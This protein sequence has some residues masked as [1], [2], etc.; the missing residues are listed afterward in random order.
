MQR[1]ASC[2]KVYLVIMN[3]LDKQRTDKAIV[4]WFLCLREN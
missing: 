4:G 2:L 3:I 1:M